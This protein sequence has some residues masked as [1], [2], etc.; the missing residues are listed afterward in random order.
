MLWQIKPSKHLKMLDKNAICIKYTIK[1]SEKL[2]VTK[3]SITIRVEVSSGG[4]T[5]FLFLSCVKKS[6]H[7]GD[8]LE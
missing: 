3:V 1:C 6:K 4:A 8:K 7:L 5:S 2:S